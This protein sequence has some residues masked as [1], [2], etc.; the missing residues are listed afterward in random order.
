MCNRQSENRIICQS[1]SVGATVT[2]LTAYNYTGLLPLVKHS[3]QSLNKKPALHCLF[4]LAHLM[5]T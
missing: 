5:N 2:P 3:L 4:A 1:I